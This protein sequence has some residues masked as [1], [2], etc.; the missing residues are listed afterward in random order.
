MLDTKNVFEKKA[1]KRVIKHELVVQFAMSLRNAC[2]TFPG[3]RDRL[4]MQLLSKQ[5]NT[6]KHKRVCRINSL[7]KLNFHRKGILFCCTD[8]CRLY[9]RL[10][11]LEIKYERLDNQ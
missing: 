11:V 5:G 8:Y 10:D 1:L 4:L 2:R 6:W 9:L 3:V 7:L